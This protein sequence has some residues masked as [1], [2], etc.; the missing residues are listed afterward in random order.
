MEFLRWV[1]EQASRTSR[2][3]AVLVFVGTEDD[4]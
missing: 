1:R 2:S 3:K 4:E